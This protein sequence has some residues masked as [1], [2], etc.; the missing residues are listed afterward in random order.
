MEQSADFT[1][2]TRTTSEGLRTTSYC[3]SLLKNPHPD[4]P[5]STLSP[6]PLQQ[7]VVQCDNS[8]NLSAVPLSQSSGNQ[9]LNDT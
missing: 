1:E 9:K 2:S 5:T 3:S 8:S 4:R 6:L 7:D